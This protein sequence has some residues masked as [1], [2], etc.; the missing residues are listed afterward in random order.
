MKE[1]ASRA[2]VVLVGCVVVWAGRAGAQPAGSA[3]YEDLSSLATIY[4]NVQS[5]YLSSYDRSGGN[6]DG[7]RG[8]YSQL[9][10]DDDGQRVLFDANGPGCIYNFWFTGS[11]RNLHWGKLRLYFDG[12]TTP[13][14]ECEARALFAGC[15]APFATPL[16]TDA[17]VS[18]GGF[19]CSAPIPFAE[20]LKVTAEKTVGFYNIYYQLYENVSL[21]SWAPQQDYSRLIDLFERCGS[22]P[23][24][25]RPDMSI[26]RDVVVLDKAT[27]QNRPESELVE[28]DR[29]GTIEH[30]KINPMFAPRV[31]DL[32]HVYLRIFYDGAK[33]PAVEVPIG[34]FFGSG[35][36]EADVRSL[37]VGMS[38]S[39][40]YYCYLPMPYRKGIRIT[41]QNRSFD[42]GGHFY[43]QVGYSNQPPAAR[44]PGRLG[45]FG[46]RYN[47]AWPLVE[48][49]D[50]VLFDRQGTGAVIGQVMTVEPV[51]PDRKRWWEGDMRIYMD[52]EDTPRFH[53]TGHEDEYQGGWSTFWLENPYSLPLFGAPKSADLINVF[54]QV[55][56][57]VT[58]Y[59]FW[60]G[61]IHF[62]NAIRI[63]TEHGNHNDTPANYS[64]LVYY[65][66][67]PE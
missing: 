63:S 59:R 42:A 20:R 4:P 33:E 10:V 37:F 43:C 18:S 6:D 9:Y 55:N 66:Y 2:A 50:Y 57:S 16:V 62:Q 12:E 46:A 52:G 34:P 67:L 49:E 13:R 30:I 28:L 56:G 14:F 47:R 19:S 24:K 40:T 35:L 15:R 31:Y 29:P 3:F 1:I 22:D 41:L 61:K 11:G 5:Y 25:P 23:K 27:G 26:D 7:F 44:P 58:A 60:P 65:Y 39:G 8:T 48:R 53:G 32:N 51:K 36:G 64:S 38:P 45:Y 21:E 54:G 17:F